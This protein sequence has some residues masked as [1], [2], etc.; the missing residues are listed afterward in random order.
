MNP[1]EVEI[2]PVAIKIPTVHPAYSCIYLVLAGV[3]DLDL[4][5]SWTF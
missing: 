4:Y 5:V 2:R 1:F 3:Y